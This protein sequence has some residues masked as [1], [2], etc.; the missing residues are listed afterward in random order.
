MASKRFEL[1]LSIVSPDK[2]MPYALPVDEGQRMASVRRLPRRVRGLENVKLPL[3][4]V[5][6]FYLQACL[7]S[8]V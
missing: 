6:T 5:A 1:L 2:R 7:R 8:R 3:T 4:V